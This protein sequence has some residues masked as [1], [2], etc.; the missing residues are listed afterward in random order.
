MNIKGKMM[1]IAL[2]CSSF[3]SCEKDNDSLMPLTKHVLLVYMGGDNN[4]S[5]ETYQKIEA[6]TAGW[7]EYPEKR[8]LIYHDPADAR[9]S[10]IEIDN[11]RKKHIL[12]TYNEQNSASSTVF[13]QVIRE[14][15]TLYPSSSYGLLVFSHASGWL[16]EGTLAKPK[17]IITDNRVEMELRD[18]ASAIPDKTFNYIVFEACFMAGIE[19]VYQL[20]D[21]TE[22]ILASSAEILSPGF[23]D[24]FSSTINTLSDENLTLFATT[25]FNY[26]DALE[27]YKHSATFSIIR[28]SGLAALANFVKDHCEFNKQTQLGDIQHFDRYKDYRLFFDFEDYYLHL[29]TDI[30]KKDELSTLINKCVVWRKATSTFM[31]GYNGFEIRKHS[32]LTTYIKQDQFL[33]LNEEYKKLKW[34]E[35]IGLE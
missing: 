1:L 17:S 29:L 9:P 4:L 25:A 6:M 5:W 14:M 8:L 28:T 13:A 33:F 26:F 20:K 2:L 21:K 34:S 27:G 32:G 16:P 12:K 35:A 23:T 19:V 31:A 3:F 24:I 7:K 15:E 11:N 10:L 30:S 18:F 22:Y